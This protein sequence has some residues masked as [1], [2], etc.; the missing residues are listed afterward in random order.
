MDFDSETVDYEIEVPPLTVESIRA[1]AGMF[2]GDTGE[3]G[4]QHLLLELVA[5]AIDQYLAG[6]AREVIIE[7]REDGFSRFRVR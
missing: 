5:N 3:R 6:Q 4:C 1:R 2:V 7:V